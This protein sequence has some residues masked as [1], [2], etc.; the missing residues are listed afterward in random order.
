MF[1]RLTCVLKRES[2]F[3]QIHKPAIPWLSYT[4]PP[5]TPG[6]NRPRITTGEVIFTAT[7]NGGRKEPDNRKQNLSQIVILR[8]SNGTLSSIPLPRRLTPPSPS[9]TRNR[10]HY[11]CFHRR[12]RS[13]LRSLYLRLHVVSA[14]SFIR[15]YNSRDSAS[16]FYDVNSGGAEFDLHYLVSGSQRGIATW[17]SV[18]TTG[19][20]W[21]RSECFVVAT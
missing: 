15:Q 8:L 4:S 14:P 2:E 12:S 10:Q 6:G 3:R 16:N 13:F 18:G 20:P 21:W 7:Q 5:L 9:F 11:R 19:T 17:G 1:A